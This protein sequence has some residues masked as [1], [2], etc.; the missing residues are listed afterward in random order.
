MK[1]QLMLIA[2]N[3]NANPQKRKA[4]AIIVSVSVAVIG[5]IVPGVAAL[6]G[7]I[8]GEVGR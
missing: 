2:A 3:L 7:P 8:S 4:I 6:A 1:N 5:L